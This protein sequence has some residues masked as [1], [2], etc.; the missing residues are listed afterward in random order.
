MVFAVTTSPTA[1]QPTPQKRKDTIP[2][3]MQIPPFRALWW[4]LILMSSGGQFYAVALTWLILDLTGSPAQ[5]G[6]VLA[7][8]AVPRAVMMLLSGTLIERVQPRLVLM[9]CAFSSGIIIAIIT[10]L[11]VNDLLT[12]VILTAAGVI[13]GLMDAFFHPAVFSVF[14]RLLPSS[15][16]AQGNAWMQG[17]EGIINML[18]PALSG[19]SVGVLGLP[20]ALSLSV[21]LILGGGL[22]CRGI[23]QV[24]LHL[25]TQGAASPASESRLQALLNGYRFA[26][27]H[28]AIRLSLLAVAAL[29]F[30]A[31]GPIVVGGAVL[32]QQ[33]FG[34]DSEMYGLF[35][36]SFGVG[37]LLGAAIATTI[38]ATERPGRIL[39]LT[40]LSLG[41]SLI[42]IGLAKE[43]WVIFVIQLV[44]SLIVVPH[45]TDK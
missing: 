6:T 8:G 15:R 23:G 25:E 39:I 38:P 45:H 16:L 34:G 36:A 17:G 27:R 22:M 12:V 26:M 30:A 37:G 1:A 21:V 4:G 32:V 19:L 11:L 24:N 3:P 9:L 10:L 42:G 28:A 2:L 7:V 20:A 40:A 13:M 29:N 41:L 43:F 33:R 5:V 44:A 35:L 18:A 14:S 31:I